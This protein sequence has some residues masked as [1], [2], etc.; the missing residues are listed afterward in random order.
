[1]DAREI[2]TEYRIAHWSGI[3]RERQ[4]SGMSIKSFCKASG[5]STNTYHY[6]QKKLREA[7]CRESAPQ[8]EVPDNPTTPI[9]WAEL[10][11]TGDGGE[12]EF[13]SSAI[14]IEAGK[15]KIRVEEEF[16]AE[17]LKKICETL[18]RLC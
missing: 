15:L 18:V 3:M 10:T 12:A 9:G 6:W 8:R 2:A 7:A 14:I 1:M 5:F 11:V 17:T 16:N 4:E 13:K